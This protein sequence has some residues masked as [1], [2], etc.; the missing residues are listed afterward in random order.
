MHIP[1]PREGHC[2]L[3]MEAK[4][5]HLTIKSLQKKKKKEKYMPRTEALMRTL[6]GM[7]GWIYRDPTEKCN[8]C[9]N[10]KIKTNPL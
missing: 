9:H 10:W 6:L 5:D 1:Q 7:N 2:H 3:E 8:I 4:A